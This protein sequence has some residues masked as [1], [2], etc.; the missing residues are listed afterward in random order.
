MYLPIWFSTTL[1]GD[2]RELSY[3]DKMTDEANPGAV[4]RRREVPNPEVEWRL[5]MPADLVFDT[6]NQRLIIAD[7]Q[8]QRVQIYNKI[9]DYAVPSR[10]I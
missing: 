1:Q 5:S 2:E 9:Q 10:T 3:W 6:L 7:T 8:R 4:R